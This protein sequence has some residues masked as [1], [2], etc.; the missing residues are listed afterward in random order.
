MVL[1][2]LAAASPLELSAG[3]SE[4][5]PSVAV[6]ELSLE[7]D[8]EPSSVDTP[9]L[10]RANTMASARI[11]ANN[12]FI[13]SLIPLF[14]QVIR[15]RAI[16]KT[17]IIVAPSPDFFNT[18]GQLQH[19][20]AVSHKTLFGFL[21]FLP[22][23]FPSKMNSSIHETLFIVKSPKHTRPMALI[24]HFCSHQFHKHC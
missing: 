14:N 15:F 13:A 3:A 7:L 22:V 11:I 12:F 24:R 10:A 23:T 4:D 16:P 8:A 19:N 21:C 6:E 2:V 17:V 18:F 5:S 20:L 9:Q 1:P